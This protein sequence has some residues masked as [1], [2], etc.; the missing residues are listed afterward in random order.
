MYFMKTRHKTYR[1]FVMNTH[2]SWYWKSQTQSNWSSIRNNENQFVKN[3][4]CDV[5]SHYQSFRTVWYLRWN[6]KFDQRIWQ[7]VELLFE[8]MIQNVL[9]KKELFFQFVWFESNSIQTTKFFWNVDDASTRTFE[10]SQIASKWWMQK[11]RFV[12]FNLFDL[13][14]NE[15]FLI[16]KSCKSLHLYRSMQQWRFVIEFY[17]TTWTSCRF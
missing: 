10:N 12:E 4:K 17:L 1:A 14:W 9:S 6:Q 11:F 7:Y 3:D 13:D 5:Y 15:N 2:S 8:K 16:L